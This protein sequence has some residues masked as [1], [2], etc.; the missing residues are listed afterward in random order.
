MDT[1]CIPVLT[2]QKPLRKKAIAQMRDI[3]EEADRVLVF[4]SKIQQLKVADS[5]YE[6]AVTL[7]ISNWQHRLWTLQEGVLN[8]QICFVLE[9]GVVT[10]DELKDEE[11]QKQKGPSPGFYDRITG[12]LQIVPVFNLSLYLDVPDENLKKRVADN[13]TVL[14]PT[15]NNRVT[16]RQE[17][18]TICMAT[19]LHLDPL[20]L[21]NITSRLTSDELRALSEA[22]KQEEEQQVCDLRMEHFLGEVGSFQANVI[23]NTLPR[24]SSIGFRWAPHTF[25]GQSGNYVTRI[26][27]LELDRAKNGS[28]L[29]SGDR[30][31]GILV[32]FP[33]VILNIP[34]SLHVDGAIYVRR[35]GKLFKT[36]L[37]IGPEYIN[38]DDNSRYSIVMGTIPRSKY[39]ESI[40][41]IFG[42]V[43]GTT[44]RGITR[45]AHICL[46]TSE[47]CDDSSDDVVE[48]SIVG[49]D[50]QWCI[51]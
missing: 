50:E 7:V 41:S 8:Q 44:K 49:K 11:G 48:A 43:E 46:A 38:I 37:S 26:P 10:L 19:L 33:G 27:S 29:R 21:L 31:E 3:Y 13:F 45:V 16:T 40:P 28:I 4:D 35:K 1:L 5:I 22:K 12:G 6:K 30:V 32:D 18:E 2:H 9:D 36:I 14:V 17:D 39:K 25:L 34:K 24:M 51:S 15:I 42:K 47:V 23:F 20:P